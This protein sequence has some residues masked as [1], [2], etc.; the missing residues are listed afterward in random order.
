MIVMTF[1]HK[2]SASAASGKGTVQLKGGR[3]IFRKTALTHAPSAVSKGQKKK[4]KVRNQL[5]IPRFRGS[6]SVELLAN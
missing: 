2:C 5:S 6:E 3:I 4:I 1:C